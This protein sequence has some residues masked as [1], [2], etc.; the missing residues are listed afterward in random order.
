MDPTNAQLAT[1]SRSMREK[2]GALIYVARYYG[3]PLVIT[4]GRRTPARQKALRAAGLS[5]IR[6]SYHITGDAFDID[7]Y[8]TDP[9][10]V[11]LVVW[12]F[13]GMVG[14]LLGLKWGGRWKSLRDY[15][16]FQ[17]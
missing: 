9:R 8:R 10:R 11:P 12:E 2:A 14:E 7:V 4:E 16:H 15:R 13:A 17:R 5:Q 3:I 1:L 6:F